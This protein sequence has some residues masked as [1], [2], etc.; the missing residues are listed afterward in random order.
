MF[1]IL[2]MGVTNLALLA[3]ILWFAI[4][5]VCVA[6]VLLGGYYYYKWFNNASY[7]TKKNLPKA[8]LYNMISIT[9]QFGVFTIF[10]LAAG[11]GPYAIGGL[12]SKGAATG[13]IWLSNIIV[14]VI[15]VALNY[16][17]MGITARFVSM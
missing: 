13:G 11:D 9:L 10:G 16:Y 12:A 17:W 3:M 14:L 7:E 8:H 1:C 6:P 15:N 2:I 4:Y 5:A